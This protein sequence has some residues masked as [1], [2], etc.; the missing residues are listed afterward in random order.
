MKRLPALALAL[1]TACAT[2]PARDAGAP[3]AAPVRPELR[4]VSR[5]ITEI[6][7]AERRGDIAALRARWSQ[8]AQAN[9]KDPST[10]FLALWTLPHHEETWGEF[11][12]LTQEFPLSAMGHVGMGRIYVEWGVLD[13]VERLTSAAAELEADNWLLGLTV[14]AAAE[15]GGRDDAAAATWRE[16]VKLDPENVEAHAGLARVALRSG[17]LAAARAEAT[18][19]LQGAPGHAPALL[20]L[21]QV[22]EKEGNLK[23]AGDQMARTVDA[24]PRDREARIAYAR[25]L[26]AEGDVTGA[27]DQWKVAVELKEDAD[28]LVALAEVARLSGD[29]A[30]EQKALERLSQADP[31][32]AEWRRIADIRILSGDLSGAERALRRALAAEPRD[33]GANL[34][35]GRILVKTNRLRD[36]VE[37]LRAAGAAGEGDLRLLEA[38]LNLEKVR[39]PDVAALQRQV[40]ALIEKTYRQRLAEL[41]R[42][43]GALSL[44][45]TVDA[46]GAGTLV[47][48][49]EDTV[50]D[51]DVLACAVWNLRDAT[52]PPN[53]PGRYS[54]TFRLRPP[55]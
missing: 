16:I 51:E 12:Y 27:R 13:Q 36:G 44:R 35:L 46:A 21:A 18:Q 24:S 49:L 45:V 42:L 32:G 52:Y 28:S 43:Q 33:Q 47:E 3:E 19:A 48:V 29:L 31:G 10:R 37:A 38:R 39:R 22:A 9:P 55:R 1:A 26:K 53:K 7:D 2:A 8:A 34:A 23:A 15:K 25:L 5:A 4:A 41:P 14:A 40:G 54:F 17:D 20:T 11:K 50:H 30:T 6:E